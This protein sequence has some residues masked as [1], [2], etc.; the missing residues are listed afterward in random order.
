MLYKSWIEVEVKGDTAEKLFG[1]SLKRGFIRKWQESLSLK[2]HLDQQMLKAFSF[3]KQSKRLQM[4]LILIN[5]RKVI[6]QEK[7]WLTKTKVQLQGRVLQRIITNWNLQVKLTKCQKRLDQLKMISVINALKQIPSKE[8]LDIIKYSE[9]V[10][11]VKAL[12][13]FLDNK[14]RQ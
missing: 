14:N 7:K 3:H 8:K 12:R 10:I 11:V 2:R 4:K 6:H 1:K 5:I 13:A 9:G